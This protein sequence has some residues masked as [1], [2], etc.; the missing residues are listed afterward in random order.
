[1]ITP[2][3]KLNSDQDFLGLWFGPM[4][5]TPN[6][7]QNLLSLSAGTQTVRLTNSEAKKI[8]S[9]FTGELRSGEP[10]RHTLIG[11]RGLDGA[12]QKASAR[13]AAL[14]DRIISSAC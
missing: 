5:F 7:D 8:D 6:P 1:M 10:W 4:A 14:F 11:I 12:E 9:E 3:T 13:N 2:K